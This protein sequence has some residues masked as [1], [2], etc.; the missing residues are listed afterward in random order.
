MG[1]F[2][3]I[4]HARQGVVGSPKY[5]LPRWANWAYT[6]KPPTAIFPARLPSQTTATWRDPEPGS[7]LPKPRHRRVRAV[8]EQRHPQDLHQAERQE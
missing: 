6:P 3:R 5:P 1:G 2:V 8:A 7:A 4:P